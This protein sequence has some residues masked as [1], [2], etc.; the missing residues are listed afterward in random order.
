MMFW[1]PYN[2]R[3]QR[4]YLSLPGFVLTDRRLSK[5]LWASVGVGYWLPLIPLKKT[6]LTSLATYFFPPVLLPFFANREFFYCSGDILR[7][8]HWNAFTDCHQGDLKHVQH[9]HIFSFTLTVFPL[10]QTFLFLCLCVKLPGCSCPMRVGSS[11]IFTSEAPIPCVPLA[12]HCPFLHKVLHSCTQW[13]TQTAKMWCSYLCFCSWCSIFA[14][15]GVLVCLQDLA[16]WIG[17]H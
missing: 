2:W 16:G 14:P 5:A 10:G 9:M 4:C 8:R 12:I 13:E 15:R 17:A 6:L 7:A 11:A 3:L 1:V